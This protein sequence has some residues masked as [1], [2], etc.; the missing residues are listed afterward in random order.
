MKRLAASK[1]R[2][3]SMSTGE[4]YEV[5]VL[6]EDGKVYVGKQLDHLETVS[7]KLGEAL[8]LIEHASPFIIGPFPY[9]NNYNELQQ[10]K[11]NCAD[12]KS[13]KQNR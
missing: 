1:A 12:E 9:Q 11:L 4:D 6:R 7:T 3:Y 10:D 8:G 5:R 2:T 13:K